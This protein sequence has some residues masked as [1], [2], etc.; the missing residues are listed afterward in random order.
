MIKDKEF[1]VNVINSKYDETVFPFDGTT[2][3]Q[4]TSDQS[5]LYGRGFNAVFRVGVMVN[6]ERYYVELKKYIFIPWIQAE[7]YKVESFADLD[8]KLEF[9]N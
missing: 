8:K 6:S 3:Y 4:V 9:T 7:K 5:K 2:Y 1:L